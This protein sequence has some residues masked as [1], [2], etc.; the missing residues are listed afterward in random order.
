[1]TAFNVREATLNDKYD[2]LLMAK[3]WYKVSGYQFLKLDNETLLSTIENF[4]SSETSVIFVVE[5]EEEI[6][7]FLACLV[8]PGLF[9]KGLAA[10]EIAWYVSED[11]RKTGAGSLL[12]DKY[13]EW[14]ESKEAKFINMTL[15]PETS[16]DVEK[17]Y[18]SK[19]FYKKESAYIRSVN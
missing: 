15:I 16:P 8:A 5:S 11:Y 12:I 10:T 19:G 7:G 6:I 13:I 18:N 1:M 2:I 17:F 14:S 3:T 9:F 4:I